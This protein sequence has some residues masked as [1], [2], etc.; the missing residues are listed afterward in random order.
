MSSLILSKE[1]TLQE[2]K[3]FA[4]ELL[5]ILPSSAIVL[6]NGDLAAGKTTL[7]SKIV[8]ILGA[9]EQSATSPTFSLQQVYGNRVFHYDFYRVEF[10]EIVHL[11]LLEEFEKEGLHFVEWADVE[12]VKLLKEAGFT[13]YSI[14][15]TAPTS[16]SREYILEVISA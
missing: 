11:G 12:L 9:S 6:L 4:Q 10:E 2:L 15:I 14:S 8:D 5:E 3:G 1:L 13:I 16:S 7:V